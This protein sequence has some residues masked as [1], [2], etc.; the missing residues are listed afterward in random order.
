MN[1]INLISE[2]ASLHV[3]KQKQSIQ[4]LYRVQDN[5]RTIDNNDYQ[6]RQSRESYAQYIIIKF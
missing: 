5:P 4:I 2:H 6:G 1:A 3:L